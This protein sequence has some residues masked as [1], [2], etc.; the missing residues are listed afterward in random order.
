MSHTDP[1]TAALQEWVEVTMR[2]S[3]RNVMRYIKE[4]GLS[5]S[6]MGALFH[7]H[8]QGSCGVSD[9]GEHLSVTSAAASQ[10]LDRLVEQ[11]LILRSEDPQ[12]RRL[13][14]VVLTEQGMRVI[15]ESLLARQGWLGGR[16][17]PR[18]HGAPCSSAGR[19]RPSSPCCGSASPGAAGLRERGRAGWAS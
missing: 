2:R 9:L 12:D 18:G 10:L 4:S 8:R 7:L 11:G 5:M 1:F 6:Q 15:H 19:R 14:Q 16:T 17:W 13:K 3:M